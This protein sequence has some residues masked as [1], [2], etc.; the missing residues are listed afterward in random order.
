MI[1]G[2]TLVARHTE[3]GTTP[4]ALDP[5]EVDLSVIKP[6]GTPE[7]SSGI[8]VTP[9]TAALSQEITATFAGPIGGEYHLQWT[10]RAGSS[11]LERPEVYF[12]SWTDVS[13]AVRRRLLET[14]QTLA[15]ADLD[16]ELAWMAREFVDRFSCLSIAG[17]YQAL[18]G[19]DQDRF[20]QALALATAARIRRSR[21]KRVPAGEIIEET[22]GDEGW[23][24]S[25]PLK[26]VKQTLSVEDEWMQEAARAIGQVT[27]V[28]ASF[29][30]RAARIQPFLMAGPT[31]DAETAGCPDTPLS[32]V[33]RILDVA[34]TDD[35]LPS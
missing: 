29:A 20:D 17:G 24:F 21:I 34:C 32:T 9:G 27:C 14:A 26:Y 2:E 8:T 13:A 7:T 35:G 33:L 28:K 18:T 5:T 15:D 4:F 22:Q 25:D 10:V 31:R 3:T 12:A 23:T 6:D 16:P 1:V 19:L 30:A 11:V